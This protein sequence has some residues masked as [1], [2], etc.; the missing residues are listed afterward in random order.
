MP[1]NLEEMRASILQGLRASYEIEAI[2]KQRNYP[3]TNAW[4][5]GYHKCERQVALDVGLGHTRGMPEP[6][7]VARMARGQ[8][9]EYDIR[10]RLEAAGKVAKD[11]FEIIGT[12]GHFTIKSRD[13]RRV[14]LSGKYDFRIHWLKHDDNPRGRSAEIKAFGPH[15]VQG[16]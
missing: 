16:V 15:L 7:Q 2:D 12:Q 5:S 9:R 8:E 1:R 6:E 3:A 4:A 14:I 11:P 10:R 13:G